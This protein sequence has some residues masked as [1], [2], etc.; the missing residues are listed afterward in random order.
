MIYTISLNSSIDYTFYLSRIRYDDINRIEEKRI[1]AGGK[2]L[3]VARML[4]VLKCEC[5]TLTFLGG[6]N[7]NLLKK[8]LDEEKIRYRYVSI[9]GNVRSVF[10]FFAGKNNVL[11]FNEQGP[12]ISKREERAFFRLIDDIKFSKEDIISI[13]GSL[14]PGLNESIY[15]NLIEKVNKRGVKT[16]LDADGEVLR[17]GIAG[18]PDIIKP[19]LWEFERISGVAIRSFTILGKVLKNI[20]NG[21]VS[22]ILLTL[23]EKGAIL[24]SQNKFLYASAPTVRVLSTIG[25]GDAFLAGF[26]YCFSRGETPERSLQMAV[27]AGTAKVLQKGTS[28][29]ERKD[30]MSIFPRVKIFWAKEL[31]A[32]SRKGLLE[33]AK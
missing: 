15:R 11:R 19:N 23:G 8:L 20:L 21:G 33:K 22:T 2:G 1:D 18:K 3:N 26:L 30:V 27:A 31:T 14:P 17:E 13:S 29:P 4:S 25:C 10:N 5:E 16:V 32:A 24:F 12:N 6:S 9:K 28:M 7:G